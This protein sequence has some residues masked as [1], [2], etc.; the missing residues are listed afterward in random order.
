M[1]TMDRLLFPVTLGAILGCALIAGLFFVFSVAIMKAFS[2]LPPEKGIAAMQSINTNI[3]NPLF[4]T[5][6]MGT[7]V[8]CLAAL[9][10]AILHWRE[11]GS[12]YLLAGAI[13]Y[14]VG[15][16]LVTAIVNVP[17]NNALATVKPDSPEAVS[18]WNRY[19]TNWTAWNHVRTVASALATLSFALAL[20]HRAA[21]AH[22]S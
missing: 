17:M 4:L 13:L 3:L 7:V 18:V 9:V 10:F 20:Y 11:P 22:A 5:V 14:L 6:F 2:V 1:A 15:A 21:A 12:A 19:L 8:V 16:F